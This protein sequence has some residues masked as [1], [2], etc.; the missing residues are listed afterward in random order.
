MQ[1]QRLIIMLLFI[2]GP[3]V[4]FLQ[5]QVSLSGTVTDSVGKPLQSVSITLKKTNG[6]LLA[7]SITNGKGA[8]LIQYTGAFIKDSLLIEANAIGFK[9]QSQQVKDT[10]QTILFKLI[11]STTNLPNVTVKIA[12]LEKKSDT[13]NYDVAT[14]S[15]KQD[16]TIG[17][18][19]KKLPGV[20]VSDNGQIS[21]GG[22]PINRF[23]IDGDN[24][25]D[26][27][28]N[29]ATKG[30][31][32]DMV[33][34]VQVLENHQPISA[35]HDVASDAAAM[36]I[37][38]KNKARLK[39]I[40][41]GDAA[42]GTPS[43]YDV[44]SN[45]MLFQKKVKFINYIKLNNI[46]SDNSDETVNHFGG[47]DAQPVSL[48]NIVTGNPDLL[49]KR[50]LFNNEG[51]LNAND[52][53]NLKNEYQLRINA[54]YLW[55]R[56]VQSSQLRSAYFLPNDTI[57]YFENQ[58]THTTGNAFN[59]QFTLTANKKQYYLNNVT[60]LENRLSDVL[61]NL[62]ATAN[63]NITQQLNGTVTNVSNRFN[64]IKRFAN[65][66]ILEGA[67]YFAV[68]HN[69]TTLNVEPGLYDAQLN[70]NIP[71]AGLIQQASVPSLVTDNYVSFSRI[72]PLFQ[73]HYRVGVNYQRRE[74]NSYLQSVQLNGAKTMVA[75]SFINRLSWGTI[76]TYVQT[77][78]TYN[79]G[80]LTITG[81]L[82]LTYQ[83]IRYTGRSL[84]NHITGPLVTPRVYLKLMTGHEA[85]VTLN[86][87]YDHRYGGIDQVYDSYIMKDYR[88][89]FN[90]NLLLNDTKINS[91]NGSY[92]YKNMLKIFFF[93]AG[94]GYLKNANNTINDIKLSSLFQQSRLIP[95]VNISE[96][97]NAYTSLSKY[98]F[99][100]KTTIS[101]KLSW[102]RVFSNTLQNGTILRLRTDVYTFGASI[103]S[104]ISSWFNVSYSGTYSKFRTRTASSTVANASA[105]PGVIKWQHELNANFSINPDL[106]FKLTGDNYQ[107]LTAGAPANNY[108][109]IDA[110]FTY[111]LNKLNT[112]IEFSLTNLSNI[113]TYGTASLFTNSIVESSY[114]IRPR[115]ALVK[116][117]FRF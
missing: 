17:D 86:Y 68:I 87:N 30:V 19:I 60:N 96:V 105:S 45:T 2:F 93:S 85:F 54:F 39:I 12:P 47:N 42:V 66:R 33:S 29:I 43:V 79:K 113:D 116:F 22:K 80:P 24:L 73:M 101:G 78:F 75:D 107:Y 46:G 108:T 7:F 27:R 6:L 35:L 55:D 76:R 110:A 50:Y 26:G 10:M 18:V 44:S 82:P 56:Q 61:S 8:Y 69:P 3:A 62:Q 15:T 34:K 71:Y 98:I 1:M 102:Q 11:E 117:Y 51:L 49:K 77:E 91:F 114:R 4:H 67:S 48:V 104:K 14:F 95:F 40:G 100:L 23:Y 5:A 53:V 103:N 109:F 74:L 99:P 84:S 57:R 111:K 97:S 90:N 16:R 28:Y 21:Y 64:F 37:V 83:D 38:L 13:L 89:F 72:W 81:Y 115:M 41:T 63:N 88:N 9:K 25:L 36:N 112:D 92:V 70:N 106:Y 20:E 31:P 52:L 94:G 59:T 65:G 58:E 32:N